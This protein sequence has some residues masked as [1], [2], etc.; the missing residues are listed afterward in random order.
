MQK[1]G[2]TLAAPVSEK[3]EPIR[4]RASVGGVPARKLHGASAVAVFAEEG[5]ADARYLRRLRPAMLRHTG[6]WVKTT[7][8]RC[9]QLWVR[10]RQPRQRAAYAVLMLGL[11]SGRPTLRLEAES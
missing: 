10:V 7:K 1:V 8:F 4:D 5:R 2:K 9:H 6:R 11:A 3:P